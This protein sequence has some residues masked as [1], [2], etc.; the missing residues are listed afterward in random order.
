M[1]LYWYISRKQIFGASIFTGL[2]SGIL[3][4]VNGIDAQAEICLQT[5]VAICLAVDKVILSGH[6]FSWISW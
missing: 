1:P 4:N 3:L 5:H 6:L 2:C